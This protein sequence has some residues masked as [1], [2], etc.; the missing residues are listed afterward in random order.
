MCAIVQGAAPPY[1]NIR[2][3]RQ[4]GF[5]Q[6]VVVVVGY[7]PLL[8]AAAHTRPPSQAAIGV[9]SVDAGGL[10]CTENVKK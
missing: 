3:F 4:V 5:V 6:D 1:E 10:I 9:E 7:Q 2:D 8:D